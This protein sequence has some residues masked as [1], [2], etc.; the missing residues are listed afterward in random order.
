[1]SEKC[2]SRSPST[3]QLKANKI[4]DIAS[5][6][7]ILDEVCARSAA[8][9]LVKCHKAVLSD[10]LSRKKDWVDDLACGGD[11]SCE[12]KGLRLE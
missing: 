9:M 2:P 6:F 3:G 1:M 8:S 7:P 5:C 12:T 11:L 10:C 4:Y